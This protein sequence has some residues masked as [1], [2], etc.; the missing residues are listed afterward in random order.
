MTAFPGLAME[1]TGAPEWL[2]SLVVWALNPLGPL[3]ILA[4]FVL[5]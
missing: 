5:L 3:F 1:R 2:A 4:G